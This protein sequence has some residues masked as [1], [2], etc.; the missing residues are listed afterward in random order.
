MFPSASIKLSG[1][2]LA[3]I[4]STAILF[5]FRA[6]AVVFPMLTTCK[7]I[8]CKFRNLLFNSLQSIKKNKNNYFYA[9][10]QIIFSEERQCKIHSGRTVEHETMRGLNVQID[11]NLNL[12]PIRTIIKLHCGSVWKLPAPI[13]GGPL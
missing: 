10:E 11:I 8:Q 5:S 12:S 1:V 7:I 2:G 13:S 9:F 3:Q 4:W 6:W